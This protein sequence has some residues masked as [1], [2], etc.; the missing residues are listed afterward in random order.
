MQAENFKAADIAQLEKPNQWN[1]A[2][3]LGEKMVTSSTATTAALHLPSNFE[4]HDPQTLAVRPASFETIIPGGIKTDEKVAANAAATDDGLP[5]PGGGYGS[6]HYGYQFGSSE[7]WTRADIVKEIAQNYNKYFTFTGDKPSIVEG[8]T[9]NLKGPLG[10]KEPVKVVA[11]NE[12]GFSFES[13]PGH[14]EGAGRTIVFRIV[15]SDSQIPGKLN[16]ELRVEA[17]GHLSKVSLIPG[18]D[19]GD[20]LIWQRF[21]DNLN[22]RLPQAP[23]RMNATSA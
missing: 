9:I 5:H 21:D 23:S 17:A 12:N 4:I 10:E 11:V 16:W 20:K 19:L 15:P 22:N 8:E 18:A 7:N 2:S 6:Y 14:S 1:P 13:L 3:L